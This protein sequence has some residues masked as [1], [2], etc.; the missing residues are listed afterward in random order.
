MYDIMKNKPQ[1]KAISVIGL[2]TSKQLEAFY[3]T[4]NEADIKKLKADF[5]QVEVIKNGW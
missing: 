2:P 3:K 1:S 4:T 5:P